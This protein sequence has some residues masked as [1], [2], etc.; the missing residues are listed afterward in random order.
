MFLLLVLMFGV[1][2]CEHQNIVCAKIVSGINNLIHSETYISDFI[3][4]GHT[5]EMPK[6]EK[7]L[8]RTKGYNGLF[9]RQSSL[10]V[11]G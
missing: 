6:W 10:A 9:S 11:R 2:F 4:N 7:L 5:V 3:F 1:M 8:A